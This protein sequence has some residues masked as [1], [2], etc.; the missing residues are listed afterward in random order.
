MSTARFDSYPL[1]ARLRK[2]FGVDTGGQLAAQLG[3]TG[4]ISPELAR[5]AETAYNSYTSG[6]LDGVRAFLAQVGLDNTQ[7]DGVIA[8][9]SA[10]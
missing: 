3:V 8:R 7:V 5:D 2:A 4:D 10:A 9:L 1:P 6:D